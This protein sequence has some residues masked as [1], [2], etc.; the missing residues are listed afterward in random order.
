MYK[1]FKK[2]RKKKLLENKGIYF[3]KREY[4]GRLFQRVRKG[5]CWHCP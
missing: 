3:F 5:G 2:G 1:F 4:V